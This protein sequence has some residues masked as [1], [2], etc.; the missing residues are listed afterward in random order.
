M[1]HSVQ[2]C[3]FLF[4][5]KTNLQL[6]KS[7]NR[8]HCSVPSKKWMKIDFD[9]EEYFAHLCTK[10]LGKSLIYAEVTS[11]T[12]DLANRCESEFRHHLISTF[13][14]FS[15]IFSGLEGN[16]PF[17]ESIVCIAGQQTNGRG[18]G[19]KSIWVSP[20]GCVY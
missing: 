20:K 8:F 18:E 6:T 14:F 7:E 19:E 12:M 13:H 11:S 1:R 5:R 3:N 17:I 2:V 10:V 4:C 15:Y 9:K 16:L